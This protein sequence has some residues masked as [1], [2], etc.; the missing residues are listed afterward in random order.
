MTKR[1]KVPR[2]LGKYL[3][4]VVGIASQPSSSPPELTTSTSPRLQSLQLSLYRLKTIITARTTAKMA[5]TSKNP[6]VSTARA[7]DN[8]STVQLHPLVLL[9][10]SDCITRHTLR[11]QTGPV[12]GAI[13]GQQNGQEITMEV[14][15]QAKLKAN[16][17]GDIV[18]DAEWFNKRLEDCTY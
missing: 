8:S 10:I 7:S 16:G 15:F 5:E 11:Q 14:A 6:L 17:A 18:L 12:V 2:G 9:T 13:I 1:A 4:P 3:V